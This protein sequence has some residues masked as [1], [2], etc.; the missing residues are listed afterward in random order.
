MSVGAWVVAGR[1]W[2]NVDGC[3]RHSDGCCTNGVG[4]GCWAGVD[5]RNDR[6]GHSAF[7]GYDTSVGDS[8]CGRS[9]D[10]SRGSSDCIRAWSQRGGLSSTD[11]CWCCHSYSGSWDGVGTRGWEYSDNRS[12]DSLGSC[13]WYKLLIQCM[14]KHLESYR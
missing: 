12:R 14:Q 9:G 8:D 6:G 2:V 4:A 10:D 13:R 1:R 5:C 7:C 3:L 11:G